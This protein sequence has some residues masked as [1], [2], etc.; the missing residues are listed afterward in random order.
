MPFVTR[1]LETFCVSLQYFIA[2]TGG[3][4][5]LGIGVLYVL[6]FYTPAWPLVVLYLSWSYTVDRRAPKTGGRDLFRNFMRRLPVFY[7]IQSY[8]PITL[9]KTTELD[10]QRNYVFGYH[11]HGVLCDGAVIGFGTEACGFSETF[12]GIVPHVSVHSCV[13]LYHLI[14]IAL[15]LP[16]PFAANSQAIFP[17]FWYLP[18]YLPFRLCPPSPPPPPP[19]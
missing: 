6:F 14:F 7:Y 2:L 17:S 11:P 12:P 1:F 16:S 3:L 4:Y 13:L 19:N 5:A 18:S 15:S 10:P 9:T 8:Y